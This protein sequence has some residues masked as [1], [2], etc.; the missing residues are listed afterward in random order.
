M[1]DKGKSDKGNKETRKKPKLSQKEKRKLK[2]E[3]EKENRP[4]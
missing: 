2:H 3:K 4:A 1:H